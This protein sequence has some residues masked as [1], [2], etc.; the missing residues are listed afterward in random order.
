CIELFVVLFLRKI[1]GFPQSQLGWCCCGARIQGFNS[2]ARL[3][4]WCLFRRRIYG[5]HSHSCWC[6]FGG[7]L[8]GL[9]ITAAW[10]ALFRRKISELRAHGC[11]VVV[12][13]GTTIVDGDATSGSFFWCTGFTAATVPPLSPGSQLAHKPLAT[14]P[15]APTE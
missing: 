13:T 3:H 9:V 2:L 4:W 11:I 10:V 14:K 15:L 6:C 12:I 7:R 5:F 8:E 1:T